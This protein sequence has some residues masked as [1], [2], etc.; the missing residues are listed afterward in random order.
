MW[1]I[2][3]PARVVKLAASVAAIQRFGFVRCIFRARASVVWVVRVIAMVGLILSL[4]TDLKP[5]DVAYA[6]FCVLFLLNA[7]EAEPCWGRVLQYED[8]EEGSELVGVTVK[9]VTE[10]VELSRAESLEK[11]PGWIRVWI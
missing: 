8:P 3:T 10:V 1:S 6:I 7:S 2:S 9:G 11:G 5:A 4:H